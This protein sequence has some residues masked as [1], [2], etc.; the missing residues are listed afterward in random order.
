MVSD[1][2]NQD[3]QPHRSGRPIRSSFTRMLCAVGLVLIFLLWLTGWRRH[4]KPHSSPIA[5]TIQAVVTNPLEFAKSRLTG[6]IGALMSVEPRTRLPRIEDVT[7]GSPA[8]RAGLS[9][10]DL[11]VKVDG[12]ATGGRSLSQ[13]VESIRGFSAGRVV[14]TV[15]RG[16]TNVDC[17]IPRASWNT[18]R[19]LNRPQ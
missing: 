11:I 2:P 3:D 5:R 1:K 13:V 8:E 6:G 10:G 17:V 14:V 18:L 12:V 4:S 15:L 19:G 16:T 7:P 9:P